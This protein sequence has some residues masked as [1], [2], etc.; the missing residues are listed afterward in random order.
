M[1]KQKFANSEKST[2]IKADTNH[3]TVLQL[4]ESYVDASERVVHPLRQPA[5]LPKTNSCRALTSSAEGK[6]SRVLVS[7]LLDS[8]NFKLHCEELKQ[9]S[10]EIEYSFSTQAQAQKATNTDQ[11]VVVKAAAIQL[12]DHG[13]DSALKSINQGLDNLI[14]GLAK[15]KLLA[16]PEEKPLNF[17]A[18]QFIKKFE[19]K[20][21]TIK[22][23]APKNTRDKSMSS[24]P[25]KP[26]VKPK[27]GSTKKEKTPV[28]RRM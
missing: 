3:F 15:K 14:K 12:E 10:E 13:V 8:R 5:K 26:K 28:H 11:K 25:V 4:E 21:K 7:E 23:T 6:Q 16:N 2:P 1:V 27:I 9:S 17:V 20:E 18:K 24:S 19:Q 22:K